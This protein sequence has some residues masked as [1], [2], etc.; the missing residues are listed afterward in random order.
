LDGKGGI[1]GRC[2]EPVS[3]DTLVAS[4]AGWFTHGSRGFREGVAET[5]GCWDVSV[6]GGAGRGWRWA[7]STMP[8]RP[9]RGSGAG[10]VTARGNGVPALAALAARTAQV[11]H[12]RGGTLGHARGILF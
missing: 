5:V 6:L 10:E 9:G 3:G 4:V 2:C 11:R 8:C 12:G 1:W 7:G